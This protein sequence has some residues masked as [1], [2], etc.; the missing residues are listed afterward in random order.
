MSD[1]TDYIYLVREIAV[2]TDWKRQMI[3][4]ELFSV[5]E[6][7]V[8][9]DRIEQTLHAR[10]QRLATEEFDPINAQSWHTSKE[11]SSDLRNDYVVKK[12]TQAFAQAAKVY[13]NVLISGPNPEIPEVAQSVE[14]T[15]AALRELPEPRLLR[16]V[17]WPFCIAG[18]MATIGKRQSFIDLA[19]VTGIHRD[20]F[21]TSWKALEVMETC[22][23][24]RDEGASRNGCDWLDAMTNMGQRILL[25]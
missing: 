9:G 20:I 18:C 16:H 5:K 6:L 3:E 10:L 2:L 17:V 21:G 24:M 14:R 7:V 23:K 1:R 25:I 11:T 22:W 4:K 15:L 12:V 13:L 8:R 19:S